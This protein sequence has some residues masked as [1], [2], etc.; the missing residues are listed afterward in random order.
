VRHEG[1]DHSKRFFATVMLRGEP[2]GTGE[3]RSKK[4]AE[5]A[6]ARV[7]WRYLRE[8][9]DPRN[10]GHAVTTGAEASRPEENDAGVT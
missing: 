6:A 8:I 10:D 9:A 5:Q 3:G 2:W 1:P 4:H 7:A